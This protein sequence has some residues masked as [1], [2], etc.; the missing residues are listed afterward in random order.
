MSTFIPAEVF[1]ETQ[2][3]L[4]R[5]EVPTLSFFVS[6]NRSIHSDNIAELTAYPVLAI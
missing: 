6:V 1:I 3:T 4:P 2:E 5:L